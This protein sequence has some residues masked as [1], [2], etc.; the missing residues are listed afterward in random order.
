MGFNTTV[1][2]LNDGLDQ[3]AKDKAFGERLANAISSRFIKGGP[4]TVSVGCHANPVTVLESH[5]ADQMKPILVGGNYG[6]IIEDTYLNYS[7]QDVAL[8]IG[9]MQAL[10][11]KYGYTLSKRSKK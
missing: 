2:V 1:L 8:E 5:H 4:V 6:H 11:K 7:I 10:A 3:I 9:L